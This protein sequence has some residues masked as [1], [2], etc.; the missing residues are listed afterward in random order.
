MVSSAVVEALRLAPASD[1]AIG[2]LVG[3]VRHVVC[4]Q[5]RKSFEQFIE[6]GCGD[7][8][9]L[10]PPLSDVFQRRDLSKEG[11]GV[12]TARARSA[13]LVRHPIA[14]MLLLLESCLGAAPGCVELQ[15]PVGMG[16]NTAPGEACVERGARSR[17][18]T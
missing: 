4:R 15:H 13:D 5:V 16:F 1:L 2:A 10:L 12:F 6:L 7:L 11:A 18:S 14:R 9:F 3:T 17:E 8:L